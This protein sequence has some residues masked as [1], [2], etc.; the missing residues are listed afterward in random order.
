MR[1]ILVYYNH[2][3]IITRLSDPEY[4]SSIISFNT[5][6]RSRG[7]RQVYSYIEGPS[8]GEWS[9]SYRVYK[10]MVDRDSRGIN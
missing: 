2:D 4:N 3:I 8:Y 5:C 9:Y 1:D 6:K 10:D 7:Y